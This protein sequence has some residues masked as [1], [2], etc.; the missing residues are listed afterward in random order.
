M[1]SWTS[2]GGAINHVLM[3]IME[4]NNVSSLMLDRWAYFASSSQV[5]RPDVGGGGGGGGGRAVG[6]RRSRGLTGLLPST[7]GRA[8]P[9]WTIQ[10]SKMC[11]SANCLKAFYG[12]TCHWTFVGPHFGP[13]Q[14][15]SAE[16][17]SAAVNSIA[18][19]PFED[20]STPFAR[21]LCPDVFMSSGRSGLRWT[22]V[23]REDPL[24]NNTQNTHT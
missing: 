14:K 11:E 15:I 24:D 16:I 3:L 20:K 17:W 23:L 2:I 12:L 10:H 5:Y 13:R 22:Q 19:Y 21:Q 4:F 1:F 6:W 9:V 7:E 8:E 18:K